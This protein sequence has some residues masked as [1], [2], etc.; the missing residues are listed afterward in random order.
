[1]NW[2]PEFFETQAAKIG[3]QTLRAIQQLLI[4]RKYPEQGYKSCA[5]V[6]A[7]AK[8]VGNDRLENA[9]ERALAYEYISAKLIESIL[10]RELDKVPIRD[11]EPALRSVIPLHPNI[12]GAGNY[13]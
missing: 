1:M 2:S 9:C 6:L 8:K 5:G 10:D 7:L 12:R 4:T 3:Q 11:E 13:K